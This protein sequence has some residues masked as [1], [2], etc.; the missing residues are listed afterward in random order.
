MVHTVKPPTEVDYDSSSFKIF[1]G[2]TIDMGNSF[3]WQADLA[4]KLDHL[5][6]VTL[7]NPRRD[8]WKTFWEQTADSP[9]FR[10]QVE[11]ELEGLEN[12]NLIV[13]YLAPG[14]MSPISLLELGLFAGTKRVLVCCPEGFYR[15][16]NID[17]V[18]QRYGITQVPTYNELIVSLERIILFELASRSV[19]SM[20]KPIDMLNN[21][22]AD[23]DT[24]PHSY[25]Q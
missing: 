1:L 13:I 2:G 3:D 20:I 12:A 10:G 14:S 11:W 4:E 17:I 18:C 23:N 9:E 25:A 8:I 7:L 16:G 22:V 24:E 6:G 21:G 15:K 19:E 5:D